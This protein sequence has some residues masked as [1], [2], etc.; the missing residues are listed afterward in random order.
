M[1][2]YITVFS[3]VLDSSPR[4]IR[5]SVELPV[6]QQL[7]VAKSTFSISFFGA[8]FGPSSL[9]TCPFARRD[10]LHVLQTPVSHFAVVAFKQN[11][12]TSVYLHSRP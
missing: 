2:V 4:P 3:A 7:I 5:F 9:L 11:A 12:L 8:V 10:S 6:R 1:L